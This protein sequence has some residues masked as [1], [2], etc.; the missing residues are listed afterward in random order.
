MRIRRARA[1]EAPALSVLALE[2][3]QRWGYA[4][5]DIERWRAELGISAA[6]ITAWPTFVA[7]VGETIAGFYSLVPA[8]DAW[9]LEHFWVAP[10]FNRRGIGRALLTHATDTARLAGA[11]SIAIDADPNAEPFYVACGAIRQ[12]AVAAPTTDNPRRSRPQLVLPLGEIV[13]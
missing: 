4:P 13:R 11:S 9:V 6:E 10:A 8:A 3:K 5:R 7:E 1:E 12:G 2:S